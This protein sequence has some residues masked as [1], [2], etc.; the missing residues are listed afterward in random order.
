VLSEKEQVTALLLEKEQQVARLL[1]SLERRKKAHCS[2][3]P[4]EM[5]LNCLDT[6][7]KQLRKI[8][9]NHEAWV[10]KVNREWE[11]ANKK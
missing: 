6:F 7:V 10:E 3:Y 1:Y 9:A 8:E 11:D 5:C 2:P 4:N